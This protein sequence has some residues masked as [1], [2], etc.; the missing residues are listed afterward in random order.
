MTLALVLYLLLRAPAA[1]RVEVCEDAE[2]FTRTDIEPPTWT[3]NLEVA[4][5]IGDHVFYRRKRG[6]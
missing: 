3:K 5:V 1:E 6:V 4:C 2:W